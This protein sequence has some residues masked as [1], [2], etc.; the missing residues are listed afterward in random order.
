M[1]RVMK[2]LIDIHTHN[3]H[4]E[5][6]SPQMVGIHPWD[7]EKVI[8]LP[9]FEEC[10]IVGET[11]LDYASTTSRE[12]QRRLFDLHLQAA[13]RLGKP[14]VIH[15]VKGT[16]DVLR[17]LGNYPTIRKVVF[18]GFIGSVQMANSILRRGY[19]LSFGDRSLRSP[20]TREVIA[21]MDIRRLFV[22]TDDNPNLEIEEVYNEVAKLRNMSVETLADEIDKNYEIFFAKD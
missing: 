17:I 1:A 7:A 10:D 16:D 22:E 12:A 6:T 9:D 2:R 14:V 18:H 13:A 3:P 5:V 21:T 15:N 20:R 8:P 4:P 11:G 19:Y